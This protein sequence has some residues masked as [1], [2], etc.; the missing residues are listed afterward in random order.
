MLFSV[1]AVFRVITSIQKHILTCC[2]CLQGKY[3]KAEPLYKQAVEIRE[4]AFG[5]NHPSV[6]TALVNLAVLLSQQVTAIF[7]LCFQSAFAYY[8][9]PLKN[10]N[11]YV[12][13]FQHVQNR[14]HLIIDLMAQVDPA[15]VGYQGKVKA[16]IVHIT[17]QLLIG[18]CKH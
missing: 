5:A 14:Q 16:D 9:S 15:K 17:H 1:L 4:K 13:G 11:V 3:D 18:L 8:L 6:A 2:F 10:C 7:G 12:L